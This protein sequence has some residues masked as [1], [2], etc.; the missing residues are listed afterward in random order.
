MQIKSGRKTKLGVN[1]VN[2]DD[3]PERLHIQRSEAKEA[4]W[5]RFNDV[6][7]RI[8]AGSDRAEIGRRSV[9]RMCRSLNDAGGT[10]RRTIPQ[11]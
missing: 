9:P 5:A 1:V 7:V 6:Q 11:M 2:H 3:H 4:E 10:A 8:D